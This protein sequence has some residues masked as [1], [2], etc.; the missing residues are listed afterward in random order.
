MTPIH[1]TIAVV[2]SWGAVRVTPFL[3]SII[4]H[5]FGKCFTKFHPTD[6]FHQVCK[7]RMY[8]PPLKM[9]FKGGE[10]RKKKCIYRPPKIDSPGPPLNTLFD[11][12]VSEKYIKI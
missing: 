12:G 6:I 7:G 10:V 3:A 8:H 5:P 9:Y 2:F 11:R 4:L 1:K